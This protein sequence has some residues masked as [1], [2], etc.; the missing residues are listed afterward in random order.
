MSTI[1]EILYTVAE[2]KDFG[3]YEILRVTGTIH[4][5][6][7]QTNIR[8]YEKAEEACRTWQQRQTETNRTLS[9]Q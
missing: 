3:I 9:A 8:T 2:N 1:S 5:E 7:V 6:V 4:Y